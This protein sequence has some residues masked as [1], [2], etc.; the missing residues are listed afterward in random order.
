[1]SRTIEVVVSSNGDI[2]IDAIG[3]KGTDCERATAYLEEALGI[4]GT[5]VKKP[6]YHKRTTSKHQQKIGG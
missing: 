3:F 5:K 4:A 1:M 6:E 2:Q